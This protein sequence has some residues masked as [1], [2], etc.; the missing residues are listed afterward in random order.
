MSN[1]KRLVLAMGLLVAGFLVGFMLQRP[2]VEP[3]IYS[4]IEPGDCEWGEGFACEAG[5]PCDFI[6]FRPTR[7]HP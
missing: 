5:V 4:D 1:D 3:Y 7:E 6:R 2:K